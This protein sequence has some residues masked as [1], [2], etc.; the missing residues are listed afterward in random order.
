MVGYG[1]RMIAGF[2]KRKTIK[3][4]VPNIVEMITEQEED[5]ELAKIMEDHM[6]KAIW[7]FNLYAKWGTL[8]FSGAAIIIGIYFR[9]NEEYGLMMDLPFEVSNRFLREIQFVFQAFFL[10]IAARSVISLDLAIN[11]LG[12]HA[13]AE[14]NTLIDYI[15]IMDRKVKTQRNFLKIILK[16]HYSVIENIDLINDINSEASFVQLGL[17]CLALM[18]GFS[19]VLQYKT[20]IGNYLIIVCGAVLSLPICILGE[21]IQ[22]KTDQLANV[23]YLTNWYDLSVSD[24][25]AFLIIL[26]MAQR[27]YRLKAA[28][29]YDVNLNA[30]IQ[31]FKMAI[32]YCAILYSLSQ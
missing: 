28:G 15:R 31:I 8:L 16:R 17:S 29:T 24:Q 27:E 23:L 9:L 30:F 18:F 19:F 26:G 10:M 2:F 14:L 11:F 21:V 13:I 6:M 12:V 5:E 7:I 22:F 20:G 25:K 3:T 32:S 1:L 4:V